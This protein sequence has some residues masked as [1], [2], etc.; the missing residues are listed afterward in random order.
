[1][2]KLR[3]FAKPI[4]SIL[5][6]AFIFMAVPQPMAYAAMVGTDAV[7]AMKKS[8]GER[9]LV[10]QHLQRED[11]RN[12]LSALGVDSA[13][14]DA[15]IAAMTDQE[16]AQIAGKLQELPAGGVD[17][18]VVIAIVVGLFLLAELIGLTDFTPLGR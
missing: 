18:I 9:A 2:D 7:S 13:A 8:E 5:T 16:V 10:Q 15:R 14:V 6:A 4:A 17:A 1:M 12:Q 3:C 11:V